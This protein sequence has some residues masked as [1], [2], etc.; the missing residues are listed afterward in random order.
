MINRAERRPIGKN[1]KRSGFVYKPRSEA[2]VKERAE[3]TGGQYDGIFKSGL[4]TFRA[5]NGDNL[6]RILPATWDDHDHYGLD[7]W[8]HGFVGVSNGSYICPAKMKNKPCPICDAAKASR[9]AGEDEEAKDLDPK[10]RVVCW[11]IDR[12]EDKPIPQLYAMSWTMDRDISALCHNAKTGK[13][14]LIDH[15]D[16]GYD[17]SFKRKGQKLNTDYYGYQIDRDS[18]PISDD[19]KEQESI[20]E[21]ITEHPVPS[22]LLYRSAEYLQGIME[23]TIEEKDEELDETA[24]DDDDNGDED[25]TTSSK[26]KKRR[27]EPEEEED[28]ATDDEPAPRKKKS[29]RDEPE[30]EDEVVEDEEVDDDEPPPRSKKRPARDEDDDDSDDEDDKPQRRVASTK[31]R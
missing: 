15:P 17:V 27:V 8:V 30:E 26:K 20:L 21:Q 12:N 31:R 28:E 18:S 23:G 22:T 2:S 5:K 16:E 4:D 14:L 6:I 7:V 25:E 9:A 19:D 1:K 24:S 11:V 3:Q 10:R 13:V 29:R